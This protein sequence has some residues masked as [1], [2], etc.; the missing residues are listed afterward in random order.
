M[1]AARAPFSSTGESISDAYTLVTGR[2]ISHDV[3]E[4]VRG[5]T[6]AIDITTGL[7]PEVQWLR[8][9]AE[10]SD[11]TVD[12]LDG[13]PL[14]TDQLIGI[15]QFA[16]PRGGSAPETS[17]PAPHSTPQK[18]PIVHD[19]SP[20]VQ[21]PAWHPPAEDRTGIVGVPDNLST[22][23]KPVSRFAIRGEFEHLDGYE[24]SFSDVELPAATATRL[25]I[26]N[27][28]HYLRGEAG[29]YRAAPGISAD[30]WL[31]DAPRQTRAQ[32]PV[33]FD[34]ATGEW[35]AHEPLR[36][37][38][39]GCGSSRPTTPDS[40]SRSYDDIF[41]ATRHLP[42]ESAQEAIQNAF[43]DLGRLHLVRSNRPDL[44]GMRD[45]S[46]VDHRAA[47]RIAMKDI[48]RRLPLVKQQRLTSE[49]TARYYYSHPAAEAFC[50]ENA[51]ILFYFLLQDAVDSNQLRMITVQPKNRPP[52]VMV[53]YTESH[54]L[55]DM[56]DAST[57]HPRLSLHQDGIS[58]SQFAWAAY[59]TRDTTVLL[60]PWSRSKA[61]S[62]AR[63]DSPQDAVDILDAAFSDI[64]H[65]TGSL[66]TVSVTRP[67]AVRKGT[68]S[69]QSSLGSVAS[70]GSAGTMSGTSDGSGVSGASSS[71]SAASAATGS[72]SISGSSATFDANP[73][74]RRHSDADTS[75]R[76][77]RPPL[78]NVA[79]RTT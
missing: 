5:W 54:R 57:P 37:C 25:V 3:R 19:A 71:A 74:V 45:H 47:L 2:E 75:W 60:D 21:S 41:A 65:R 16:S 70:A 63:A 49:V 9:P 10:I 15:A 42:D 33:T 32:V 35:A 78:Q 29:Y 59:M 34:P 22:G 64:G 67:L 24:Q 23:E 1:A 46:I 11:I 44:R 6:T 43:A 13:K 61:I 77:P 17:H 62:F 58:S 72:A 4:K 50:Q 20:P 52:H 38:G 69:S 55:I 68:L 14:S 7:I 18:G 76:P 36:M 12:R 26:V 31:I 53:L 66:Y 39:G 40:I 56:L 27:G 30:H 73:P 8:L 51:E 79:T 48:D 28:H